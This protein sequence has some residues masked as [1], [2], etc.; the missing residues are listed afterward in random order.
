MK[1][2]IAALVDNFFGEERAPAA[3]AAPPLVQEKPR[4]GIDRLFKDDKKERDD[5]GKVTVEE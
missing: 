3:A 4:R 2:R 1:Y 5:G